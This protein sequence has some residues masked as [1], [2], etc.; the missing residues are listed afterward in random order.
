M[1]QDMDTR[2]AAYQGTG[3]RLLLRFT[4]NFGPIG[5]GS[6]DAPIDVIAQTTQSLTSL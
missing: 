4:Y 5:P 6:M 1:L 3:M 2:L